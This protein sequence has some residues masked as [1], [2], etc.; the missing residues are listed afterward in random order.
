VHEPGRWQTGLRQ[1][2]NGQPELGRSASSGAKRGL[3]RGVQKS[4]PA[5]IEHQIARE[6]VG[7]RQR[8]LESYLDREK[9]ASG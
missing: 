6:S 2:D 3:R 8:L 4:K 1:E 5:F 7:L 9:R